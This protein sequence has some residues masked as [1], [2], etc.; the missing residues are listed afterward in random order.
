MAS[1]EASGGVSERLRDVAGRF[2]SQSMPTA[3]DEKV[4]GHVW[5]KFVHNCAIN[6]I[7]A[8]TGLRPGEIARTP[9]A[10]EL[11]D[12]ALD[13]ILAVAVDDQHRD[14]VDRLGQGPKQL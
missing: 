12:R 7:S 8:I 13:E 4:M 6:P 10:A 1:R 9:A 3:L 5:S 2:E 11:L 14:G